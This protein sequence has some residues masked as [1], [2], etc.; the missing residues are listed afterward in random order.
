MPD[1]DPNTS[2]DPASNS[3][4]ARRPIHRW[5]RRANWFYAAAVVLL[6]VG[7]GFYLVLGI[8]DARE[9]ARR[10]TCKGKLK[11]LGLALLNYHETYGCFPRLMSRTR[12]VVRCTVGAC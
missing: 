10:S 2:L 3:P 5:R 7:S 4:P 1:N 11:Q 6:L 12:T 9:A 8:R